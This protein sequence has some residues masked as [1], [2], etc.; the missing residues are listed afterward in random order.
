MPVTAERPTLSRKSSSRCLKRSVAA[1]HLSA[2]DPKVPHQ[3]GCAIG[4]ALETLQA[5]RAT[6]YSNLC[7]LSSCVFAPWLNFNSVIHSQLITAS[8]THRARC[9]GW[10]VS[11]DGIADLML[12]AHGVGTMQ[13][14]WSVL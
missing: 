6:P 2:R 10:N 3:A 5:T 9:S 8:A 4:H 7:V 14:A 1:A 12:N 13:A 11:G